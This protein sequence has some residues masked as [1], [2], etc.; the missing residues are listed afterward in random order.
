MKKL[1]FIIVIM[2]ALS[3]TKLL[4]QD[5][6][7]NQG[8]PMGEYFD[9]LKFESEY[10]KIFLNVEIAGKKRKF[11]F[12]TGSTTMISKNLYDEIKPN[13][14]FEVASIDILKN[15][16]TLKIVA[17]D[18]IKLG[19]TTFYDTPSAVLNTTPDWLEC[20]N[21]DGIIGSN[22]LRNSIVQI[23]SAKQEIIITSNERN[24]SLRKSHSSELILSK[25]SKP[26][27]NIK[28]DKIRLRLLFD[29]GS[30]ELFSLS[31]KLMDKIVEK[32]KRNPFDIIS[33]G[34]GS[35]S[36]GF[37]GTEKEAEKSRIDLS[38]LEINTLKLKSLV[39][40]TANS[41]Q[42]T[43]GVQLINYGIVTI[44]YKNKRFYIEPFEEKKDLQEKKWSIN[45]TVIDGYLAVGVVWGELIEQVKPG[46]KIISLDGTNYE[47]VDICELLKPKI[48]EKNKISLTIEDNN[49]IRKNIE[50]ERK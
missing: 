6:T 8:G 18:E 50:L 9:N 15:R 38:T 40:E 35:S 39:V 45:L 47:N 24:L 7:F 46:D 12:D 21:I 34:Y 22:I 20:F 23:L 49:G 16:D 27:I 33:I 3:N 31:N 37:F 32:K 44:D 19:N 36:F 17:I 25:E 28:A 5:F 43:I 30:T 10:G 14:I 29:T 41:I 4:A 2:I 1:F 11:L 42:S 26:F 13:V 48:N